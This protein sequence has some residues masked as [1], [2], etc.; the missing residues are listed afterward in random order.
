MSL[1]VCDKSKLLYFVS[2]QEFLMKCRGHF[3]VNWSRQHFRTTVFHPPLPAPPNRGP[4]LTHACTHTLS[5]AICN[6]L[7][8]GAGACPVVR[9]FPEAWNNS[10]GCKC[11]RREVTMRGSPA[12]LAACP[13]WKTSWDT[14]TRE[15]WR[16]A[17]GKCSESWVLEKITFCDRKTSSV[18]LQRLFITGFSS[19][20][21][22]TRSEGNRLKI[23][24]RSDESWCRWKKTNSHRRDRQLPQS[25]G[26]WEK[27]T[28]EALVSLESS[29]SAGCRLRTVGRRGGARGGSGGVTGV[30]RWSHT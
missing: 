18:F 23:S 12:R 10:S 1:T 14:R 15:D 7:V 24:Y 29:P 17:S 16:G 3:S 21:Q 6:L 30:A 25:E 11:H 27:E 2:L 5:A 4:D 13:G 9:K 28:R 20:C 26:A 8:R 19:T 22:I